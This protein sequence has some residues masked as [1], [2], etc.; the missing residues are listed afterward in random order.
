MKD[1]DSGAH[2]SFRDIAAI[3][4]AA[5]MRRYYWLSKHED[6]N[7]LQLQRAHSNAIDLWQRAI[8]I[9]SR[10]FAPEQQSPIAIPSTQSTRS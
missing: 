8:E 9:R 4:D 1:D 6:S 5:T 2:D 10:P 3:G 7:R